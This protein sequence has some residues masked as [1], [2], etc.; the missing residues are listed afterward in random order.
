M[1]KG[2]HL[3]RFG[4]L[5]I[6][7][8]F[9]LLIF[10]HVGQVNPGHVARSLSMI[11]MDAS[12]LGLAPA[13]S[14][15]ITFEFVTAP[16]CKPWRETL[17]RVS[18]TQK[19]T[20]L[21]IARDSRSHIRGD[22]ILFAAIPTMQ[23]GIV[24]ERALN[25]QS[26][27]DLRPLTPSLTTCRFNIAMLLCRWYRILVAPPLTFTNSGYFVTLTEAVYYFALVATFSTVTLG[28]WEQFPCYQPSII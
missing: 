9:I 24:E 23:H 10:V 20:Q 22:C 11:N 6:F 2:E 27:M 12:K 18:T 21:V 16:H 4:A 15:P 19:S 25:L 13:P 8:A 7:A 1:I 28:M 17:F 26:A 14:S 3:L 5:L